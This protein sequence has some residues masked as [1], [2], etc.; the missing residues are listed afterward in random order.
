MAY[1]RFEQLSDDER[2]VY[3]RMNALLSEAKG[4]RAEWLVRQW[5]PFATRVAGAAIFSLLVDMSFLYENADYHPA[6]RWL[7]GRLGVTP[8]DMCVVMRRGQAEEERCSL[9]R[10]LLVCSYRIHHLLPQIVGTLQLVLELGGQLSQELDANALG[11]LLCVAAPSALAECGPRC[12]GAIDPNR[13]IEGT[14]LHAVVAH[15]EFI[16]CTVAAEVETQVLLRGLRVAHTLGAK[17]FIRNAQG[18]LPR[19]CILAFIRRQAGEHLRL[20]QCLEEWEHEA[21]IPWRRHDASMGS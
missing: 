12:L 13:M 16:L 8:N 5:E 6:M 20:L 17:A 18:K 11:R 15:Y 14:L 9:V 7:V 2:T 4:P 19:H 21:S 3:A 10:H 1:M